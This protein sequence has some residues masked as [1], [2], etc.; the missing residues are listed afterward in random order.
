[1]AVGFALANAV[2]IAIYNEIDG[3]GVRASGQALQYVATP[4]LLDGWSFALLMFATRGRAARDL[5][6]VRRAAGRGR[7]R[8][9]RYGAA[10]GLAAARPRWVRRPQCGDWAA[11]KASSPAT[12][13]TAAPAT[14]LARGTSL[15]N[16]KPHSGAHR[17]PVY[18]NEVTVLARATR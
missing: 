2:I 16:R 7:D 13:I 6:A 15:K 8:G 11:R 1:M 12:T 5:G 4:F 9:R 18:S 3:L 17:M 10:L 14:V